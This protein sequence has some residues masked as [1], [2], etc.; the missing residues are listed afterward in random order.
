MKDAELQEAVD[1][2]YKT[3]PTL[4]PVSRASKRRALVITDALAANPGQ[5]S[6]H[7][8]S[9]VRAATLRERYSQ[10]TLNVTRRGKRKP[11]RTYAETLQLVTDRE[12]ERQAVIEKY[13]GV[14]LAPTVGIRQVSRAFSLHLGLWDM[15]RGAPG[16]P[17]LQFARDDALARYESFNLSPDERKDRDALAE[18]YRRSKG[19]TNE[20]AY[21]VGKEEA[22]GPLD[23]TRSTNDPTRS[24]NEVRDEANDRAQGLVGKYVL[25]GVVGGNIRVEDRFTGVGSELDGINKLEDIFQDLSGL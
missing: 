9:N 8:I 20:L 23:P 16:V 12:V 7:G 18:A 3:V 1:E 2:F 17:S 24:T 25:V 6:E 13:P 10:K 21:V 22:F 4:R 14:F 19:I 5:V 11:I 15:M